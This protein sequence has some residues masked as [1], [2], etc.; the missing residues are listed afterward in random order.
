MES[1]SP[2]NITISDRANEICDILRKEGFFDD[3]IEA[4]R[5]AICIAIQ[6]D[7]ELDS[8][9]RM[10]NNKW[11]TAAVFRTEGKNLESMMMLLGYSPDEIV[12]KG[13]LLAEAGL[14]Y[15]D[16]KRIANADLLSIILGAK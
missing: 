2:K 1:G 12:I 11:D 15:L 5:T 7:L 14:K 10:N 13:K 3:S 8:T 4:Y 9:V 16:E 6:L